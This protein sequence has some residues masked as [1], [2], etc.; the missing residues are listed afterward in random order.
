MALPAKSYARTPTPGDPARSEAWAL[1]EAARLMDGAKSKGPAELLAAL[2]KNWRLWTIF[3]AELID[4]DCKLPPA[5]RGNLLGL[6]NFIDHHTARLLAN[7][8]PKKIDVLVNINR[9]ISEGLLEGQRAADA[10][11]AQA[12]P[13]APVPAAAALRESA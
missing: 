7:P 4:A 12:A 1:L 11:A 8:D 2:R 6:A 9:Q 3:Q 10:K 13:V 5:L